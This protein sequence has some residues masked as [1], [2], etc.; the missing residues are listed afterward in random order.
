MVT[1]LSIENAKLHLKAAIF[2]NEREAEI[3]AWIAETVP[4]YGTKQFNKRFETWLNEKSSKKWGTKTIEDWGLNHESK[5][6]PALSFYMSDE[7]WPDTEGNKRY[8]LSFNYDGQ[9]VGSEGYH[10][11]GTYK[12]LIQKHQENEKIYKVA[13]AA[14]IVDQAVNVVEIRQNEN[15]KLRANMKALPALKREHDKL[16]AALEAYHDKIRYAIRDQW[17]IGR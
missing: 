1:P 6:Y 17:K 10:S 13:S 16:E 11:E 3:Y 4:E 14:E 9:Q 8:S 12:V 2:N 7:Q 15:A 5:T